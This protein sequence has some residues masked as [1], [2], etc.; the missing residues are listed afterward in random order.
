MSVLGERPAGS[1]AKRPRHTEVNEKS[2]IGHE[3]DNQIL[4]AASDAGDALACEL[5]RHDI[6]VEGSGESRVDD[7]CPLYPSA[8]Q[9]GGN[10]ASDGLDLGQLRHR[11]SLASA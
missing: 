1:K 7:D 10:R 9:R 4:A 6:R 2:T 8:F 11:T 5:S 3:L